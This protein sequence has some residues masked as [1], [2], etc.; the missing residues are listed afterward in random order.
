MAGYIVVLYYYPLDEFALA[1]TQFC[2]DS[3]C[4]NC[5]EDQAEDLATLI[6]ALSWAHVFVLSSFA[7]ALNSSLR[8]L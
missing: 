8:L 3:A 5:W 2:E 6:A 4:S 7:R 1:R